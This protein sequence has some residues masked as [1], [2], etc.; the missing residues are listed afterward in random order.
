MLAALVVRF[1]QPYATP[2]IP[3]RV[4]LCIRDTS[5]CRVDD[6]T[7]ALVIGWS[8]GD[9]RFANNTVRNRLTALR[10]FLLWCY[11]EGL[12]GAPMAARPVRQ[13]MRRYPATYGKKQ[14]HNPPRW[15]THH[16]AYEQLLGTCD[17]SDVGIRD[18]ILIR[19]GLCGMRVSELQ[20]LT[21]ANL[22]LRSHMLRWMG[23]G[24]HP[25]EATISPKLRIALTDYLHRYSAALDRPLQP[26]DPL[27]CKEANGG[28]TQRRG[29]HVI[30]WGHPY[31]Y[32]TGI[33][34]L[35]KRH[36]A[37]PNL[38]H[39]APH[40]LRR[41]AAGILH[42]ATSDDG[43]H[44]FDLLDI[45]K[46]LGHASPATT[47]RSYLDPMDTGVLRRAADILD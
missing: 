31:A 6:L 35:L 1:A 40:D 9:G 25:R 36:A 18:Q 45:Q 4:R 29:Q 33:A 39:I 41:T 22:D 43:A 28:I 44:L 19:L 42:H 12:R 11:E 34:D 7:D 16:E 47:M 46:V 38:G 20:H 2:H 17:D 14:G 8:V 24:N 26:N 21:I 10:S 13:I 27:I 23:K 30:A 3:N 5:V 15:L 32:A 37:A